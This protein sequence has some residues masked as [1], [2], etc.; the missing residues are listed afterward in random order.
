MSD[1]GGEGEMVLWAKKTWAEDS[2]LIEH[3]CKSL[4]P[5]NRAIGKRIKVLAG[6][7]KEN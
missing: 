2:E 6:V 7:E 4:D 1:E 3:M 5:L